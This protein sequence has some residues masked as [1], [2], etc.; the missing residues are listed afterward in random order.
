MRLLLAIALVATG[1]QTARAS[2]PPPEDKAP[3]A[4]VG[5][6]SRDPVELSSRPVASWVEGV[7]QPLTTRQSALFE[8]YRTVPLK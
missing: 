1:C 7:Q 5:F 3:V 6:W 8:K 2:K 4:G